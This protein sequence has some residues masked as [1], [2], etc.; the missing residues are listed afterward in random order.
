MHSWHHLKV[1]SAAA[2]V[3]CSVA[4][5]PPV[6]AQEETEEAGIMEEILVTAQKREESLIEV[7]LSLSVVQ[8]ETVSNFKVVA[9]DDLDRWVPNFWVND[10]PGNNTVYIRGIGTTPGN[11]AFEQSVTLFVDGVYAGRARQFQAPFVDIR[12]IGEFEDP[13]WEVSP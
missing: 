11:L 12:V 10:S 7:P 3:F 9:F 13:E 6:L 8:G 5:L 4:S 2:V 1:L